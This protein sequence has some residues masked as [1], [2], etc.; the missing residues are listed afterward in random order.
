MAF[1]FVLCAS[2]AVGAT[3]LSAFNLTIE[4]RPDALGCA[5][6]LYEDLLSP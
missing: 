5:L 6:L 3:Q 4:F 1:I 2:V